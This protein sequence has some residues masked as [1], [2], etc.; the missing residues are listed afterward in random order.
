LASV[1]PSPQS[2]AALLEHV[3]MM[4]RNKVIEQL[5]KGELF[6]TE[7]E[8]PLRE[9]TTELH[10]FPLYRR[11]GEEQI[12]VHIVGH[13]TN[14]NLDGG[15]GIEKAYDSFLKEHTATAKI[16]YYLD[17]LGRSIQGKPPTVQLD[18]RSNGGVVLTIDSE[19][20][21]I[22]EEVGEK[23]LSKGAVV[24]MTP[25]G[26]IRASASFPSFDPNHLEKSLTDEE[27]K[28]MF[29]RAFA[30]YNVGSTFKIVT[31]AAALESGIAPS[32]SYFC[33][34]QID[35][36]GQIIKCHNHYGHGLLKMEQAMAESCNPYYIS[37]GLL[38][39]P[40]AL[41]QMA[42][43]MSF[44]KA[45]IL[46]S[47]FASQGG[48]LPTLSELNSPAAIANLS[49]G[50]GSL[51]ATPIQISLMTCCIVN[52]GKTPFAKLVEGLSEDG[53]VLSEKTEDAAPIHAI[54]K[55]TADT[56]KRF[57]I[58]GVMERENQQA[59]PTKT[60]AGGKTAT[61]Q[62]GRFRDGEE[63]CQGWFTG[64]FPA[65]EPQ[66]IVT[67]LCED[68]ESGNLSA[69]PVFREIADRVTEQ[70]EE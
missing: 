67:V 62:T 39:N 56:V 9:D 20:Q 27:N 31:A 64:F 45:G 66:Y 23:Y 35:V 58:T 69:G 16:T 7:L 33:R 55:Q 51:S 5:G 43:D 38:L 3:P 52:Q 18:Q 46:A 26:K 47:G 70:M 49:F 61:A 22:A 6:V 21:R 14:G 32:R 12:A 34:G 37:L 44:S 57:L 63:I 15:Y 4:S 68:A 10:T 53:K 48:Y 24:V 13:M 42:R 8:T 29:N 11:Y 1:L 25:D 36:S 19:I 41:L 54:R 59:K 65:E 2:A 60:T 40:A 17:A 30:S 50:Q 28:P